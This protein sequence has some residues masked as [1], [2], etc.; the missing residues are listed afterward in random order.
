VSRKL[1]VIDDDEA[2]C[3]L[4]R[5]IFSA[6]GYDV[7]AAHDGR[8]GL[9]RAI[10][11][12]P[13]LV[14]LDL[15]LPEVGG[16]EVLQKLRGAAPALPIVM[17]TADRDLKSA[18]RATQLGAFDYLTKPIDQEEILIVVRRALE[19]QALQT[20]VED[21]RRQ[22]SDGGSLATQ[23]GPSAQIKDVV[24]QVKLVAS[25]NFTVLILGETGT[26][27]EVVAQAIHRA[28]ERRQKPFV[29]VDCGAIPEQLLESEL[30]GHERGAFTGADRRKTGRFQLAESGTF[31][32]DEV[33]NLPMSLQAKLLRVLESRQVQPVGGQKADP[34]DVRFV[35]ATN[36]DL[37]ERAEAGQFRSDLYFRLA[38][39]T[40]SLPALRERK[41]DIAHLADRFL[42]EASIELRHPVQQILPQALEVLQDHPWPGNVRELRNV[43]RQAVLRTKDMAIRPDVVRAILRKPEAVAPQATASVPI[44]SG[45]KS[46]K[47]IAE[48]AAQVAE[49][50]AI[51]ETLRVTKGNKSQA[52]KVLRT[53]YKTLHLKMNRFGIRGRDFN[54]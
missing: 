36:H 37:Q 1:L 4:V 21:L 44:R 8:S 27:K 48:E 6:E 33:G 24:E 46:L 5:A 10:A 18:V 7:V 16:L 13:N 23:M 28:S 50:Q 12:V 14:F 43:V 2:S 41:S 53:D 31:F 38:Q 51:C 22:L 15:G 29:A 47:E 25:S 32:L 9:A 17:L 20:E 39:Y 49:R 30:F 52:A 11:D 3:R 35:A 42:Q 26:G 54:P 34:L 45:E 40:I 19:V